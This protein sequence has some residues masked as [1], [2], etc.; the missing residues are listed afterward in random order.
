MRLTSAKKLD[1]FMVMLLV[2][3]NHHILP[4]GRGKVNWRVE[5]GDVRSASRN[6]RIFNRTTEKKYVKNEI[7]FRTGGNILYRSRSM[8]PRG[9]WTPVLSRVSQ[10]TASVTTCPLNVRQD[11]ENPGL[12]LLFGAVSYIM[13]THLLFGSSR[14]FPNIFV[15]QH[16]FG[17]LVEY[18]AGCAQRDGMGR[19][20]RGKGTL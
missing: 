18:L 16:V 20:L 7:F 15:N 2:N 14:Y 6:A 5:S 12:T 4:Y 19:F 8:L 13:V 3:D 9:V 1:G 17:R 11:G 10:R